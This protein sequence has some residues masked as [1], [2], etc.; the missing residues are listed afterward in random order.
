MNHDRAAGIHA[1]A[2][3]LGAV[4]GIRVGHV[5]GE[6]VFAVRVFRIEEIVAF[7]RLEVA[8]LLLVTDRADAE[9]D[10]EAAERHAAPQ[11]MQLALRLFDQDLVGDR[12]V[13]CP[14]A[15]LRAGSG[16][17]QNQ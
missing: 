15:A 1:L 16:A 6:E 3:S 8:L 14:G 17:H 4:G 12:K 7:G 2:A 9:R 5:D 11:Q 10:V 13:V